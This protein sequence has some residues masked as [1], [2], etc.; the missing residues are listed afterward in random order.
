MFLTFLNQLPYTGSI[1]I[2]G[3]E[4]RT[5]PREKLAEIITVVPQEFIIFPGTV[6][7]NLIPDEFFNPP[8]ITVQPVEDGEEDET[9]EV[10]AYTFIMQ[11]ILYR[12]GLLDIINAAGG[13]GADIALVSMSTEQKHR[14]SLGQALTTFFLRQTKITLVDDLTSKVGH[15]DC[16]IMRQAIRE[17]MGDVT[18]VAVAHHPSAIIGSDAIGE[19][20]DNSAS[21][22][23][24]VIMQ[25]DSDDEEAPGN[26]AFLPTAYPIPKIDPTLPQNQPQSQ[27]RKAGRSH[28]QTKPQRRSAVAGPSEPRKQLQQRPVVASSTLAPPQPPVPSPTPSQKQALEH[29]SGDESA[30][31]DRQTQKLPFSSLRKD[32]SETQPTNPNST[33]ASKESKRESSEAP[34]VAP[35]KDQPTKAGVDHTTSPSSPE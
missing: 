25:G 16:V 34:A 21:M 1:T 32:V 20:K 14:F 3:V 6:R 4:V 22:R 18:A 31:S 30:L 19:I 27:P 12:L 24:R 33:V 15:G 5:I 28:G 13:L 29:Q 10:E 35:P 2:D 26:R 17:L 7:Q 8:E 9:E 23:K 11:R